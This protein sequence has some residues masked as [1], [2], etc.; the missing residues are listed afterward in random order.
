MPSC[1]SRTEAPLAVLDRLAAYVL[2]VH[3]EEVERAQDRAGVGGVA[4]DEVEDGQAFVV[5]DD[6]LAVNDARPDGQ[7]LDRLR[8]EREAVRQ[9]VPVASKQ[10]DTSA[11]PM[12]IR[13]P[14][15]FDLVKPA[16]ARRRL[17]GRSR[18]SGVEAGNGL[19]GAQPPPRVTCGRRHRREDMLRGGRVESRSARPARLSSFTAQTVDGKSGAG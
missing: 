10:A 6:G 13:K 7:C 1:W 15:C 18:Q 12:R 3:L 19:L 11:P 9:V 8:D 16:R 17:A 14:S 4:A 5:A 2:A